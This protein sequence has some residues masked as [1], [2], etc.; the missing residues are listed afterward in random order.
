MKN[1]DR[2]AVIVIRRR[3]YVKAGV[4]WQKLYKLD[5]SQPH[6]F[7]LLFAV[8]EAEAPDHHMR[9]LS[10]LRFALATLSTPMNLFLCADV[11]IE[12]AAIRFHEEL[13]SPPVASANESMRQLKRQAKRRRAHPISEA[14]GTCPNS[15]DDKFPTWITLFD[16]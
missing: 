7:A 1:F 2:I 15:S 16:F 5:L 9:P 13:I 8:R 14:W 10:P 4:G 3:Q 6:F 11:C 12:R